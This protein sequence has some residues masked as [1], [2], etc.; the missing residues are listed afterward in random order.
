[1]KIKVSNTIIIVILISILFK[2]LWIFDNNNLGNF[3]GDDFSYWLHSSTLAFDGDINYMNDYIYDEENFVPNKNIPYHPPGSGYLISIFVKIFSLFDN[4]INQEEI[5]MNPI[6]TFSYLGFLFGN[7]FF[8]LSGFILLKKILIEISVYKPIILYLTFLSTLVHF[9][10]TRFLMSHSAEFFI[11]CS[12]L[13]FFFCFERFDKHHIYIIYSL[14]F[15][16]LFT[17]PSTFLYTWLLFVIFRKKIFYGYKNKIQNIIA[18]SI[19]ILTYLL[20]SHELYDSYSL[21]FNPSINKTSKSFFEEF[22]ILEILYRS[23]RIPNLFFST[24]MGIF[25]STPIIFTALF[26]LSN[27]VKMFELKLEKITLILYFLAPFVI[28]IVWGGQEVSYGQRLLVGILPISAIATSFFWNSKERLKILFPILINTYLGYLFFYS[29]K[30]LTLSNGVNL[31][32][33]SSRFTAENYYTNLYTSLLSLEN[34]FA[35]LTKNVYFVGLLKFIKKENLI[36]LLNRVSVSENNLN[37]TLAFKTRYEVF[38]NDYFFS[39]LII[40]LIFSTLFVYF[41]KNSK[42]KK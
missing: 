27:F 30:L 32:G 8:V 13:Y 24:N 38:A 26:G 37:N 11:I 28:L 19:F 41:L 40:V 4:N 10:T 18:M 14:F 22:Q 16:L 29:N 34:I 35:A 25:Y 15:I 21:L 31:W 3:G 20:L 39:Y 6:G 42:T 1:M 23:F 33:I 36:S 7:L 12:I 17:R 2:P 5:R 9:S